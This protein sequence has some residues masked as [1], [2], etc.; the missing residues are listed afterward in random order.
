M[1]TQNKEGVVMT[2]IVLWVEDLDR[3]S[4]FYSRLLNA[5]VSEKSETFVAVASEY[6]EVLLHL[7]P[8]QYREGIAGEPTVREDSVMK[9]VFKVQSI[10][11]ARA[12]IAGLSGRVQPTETEQVYQAATYCDGFDVEGNVFQLREVSA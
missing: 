12:A 6:N 5:S 11:A 1:G 3:A 9:P 10:S 7:V 4:D 8:E 2:A